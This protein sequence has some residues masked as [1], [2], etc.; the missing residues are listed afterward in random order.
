MSLHNSVRH[1][2]RVWLVII[3][4][5]AA[6]IVCSLSTA[7]AGTLTFNGNGTP[8]V[9]LTGVTQ[10]TAPTP[11]QLSLFNFQGGNAIKLQGIQSFTDNDGGGGTIDVSFSGSGTASANDILSVGYHFTLQLNGTGTVTPT[12]TV[13]AILLGIFPVNLS[14]SLGAA[15]PGTTDYGPASIQSPPAPVGGAATFTAHAIFNWTG[16]TAGDTLLINIPPNSI[17]FAL[18]SMAIPEPGAVSLL[19]LAAPLVGWTRR[20]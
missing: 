19:L 20:R 15:G 5:F 9:S 14:G 10:L 8:T 7:F 1:T 2:L 11:F 18:A 6:A 17:D 16:G 4:I 13:N 12:V 3:S